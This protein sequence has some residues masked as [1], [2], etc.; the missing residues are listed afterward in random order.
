MVNNRSIIN[1]L[2]MCTIAQR[3]NGYNCYQ[4]S[5]KLML[6]HILP[7][8]IMFQYMRGSTCFFS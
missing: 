8:K 5:N 6:V 1:A 2:Q 4:P 7:C 3:F